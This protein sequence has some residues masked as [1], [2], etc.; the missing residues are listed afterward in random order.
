MT[1]RLL[2]CATAFA[3][4]VISGCAFIR[5]AARPIDV[6]LIIG[7][8]DSIHHFAKPSHAL[9]SMQFCVDSLG[10]PIEDQFAQTC[11]PCVSFEAQRIA[12]EGL[13]HAER[14]WGLMSNAPWNEFDAHSNCIRLSY[15]YSR[16]NE[17]SNS[18]TILSQ[19]QF[20]LS[21]GAATT[22]A[23]ALKTLDSL[24]GGALADHDTARV[25]HIYRS[26]A[27]QMMT[28]A[29]VMSMRGTTPSL[30]VAEKGAH[31]II[32]GAPTLSFLPVIPPTSEMLGES[33]AE[34]AALL[35]EKGIS[36]TAPVNE[37]ARL[38]RLSLA[39]FA[40]AGL[41]DKLDSASNAV[42]GHSPRDSVAVVA[43]ALASYH[44]NRGD[45]RKYVE[46][47]NRFTEALN[48]MPRADSAEY[49][50]F[51]DV[52]TPQDDEWRFGFLPTVRRELDRRA[53]AVVDPLWMT[54]VNEV[55]LARLA[56]KAEGDFIYAS[57]M[58]PGES[59]SASDPGILL[60]KRGSP[61]RMWRSSFH[62]TLHSLSYRWGSQYVRIGIWKDN[63]SW[64]TLYH[65]FFAADRIVK[66]RTPCP[67]TRVVLINCIR[68][69]PALWDD[70]LFY[71]RLDTIDVSLTRFRG[72]RDS[73]D[74]HV[75]ARIP[76]RS[77]RARGSS[78]A[79]AVDSVTYGLIIANSFGGRI[80]ES[81]KSRPLPS[82]SDVA[83][84]DQWTTR[85]SDGNMMHRVEAL[86]FGNARG[87]RGAAMFTSA[88]AA[89]F[90]LNGFGLSEILPASRVTQKVNVVRSWKDL[91]IV[92]NGG[93]VSPRVP[94]HL[95]WEVYGLEAGSDGQS[96]WRVSLRREEGKLQTQ[97]D[98]KSMIIGAPDQSR[99]VIASEP[100]ASGLTYQRI[101]PTSPRVVEQL[102]FNL[103]DITQGR[104][105]FI[106]TV[107]D[108]IAKKTVRREVGFSILPQS[109]QDR[110]NSRHVRST[111]TG[112][113][114]TDADYWREL[115]MRRRMRNSP[116]FP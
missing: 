113:Q 76:T 110:S 88:D 102:Q 101:A 55:R 51:T 19:A 115:L 61:S 21:S 37:K 104:H 107:E 49:D 111:V 66:E 29:R 56:R 25:A 4:S 31:D 59:G 97:F 112:Y 105:V 93:V 89:V 39:S 80:F 68:N 32:L 43:R 35:F 33:E 60:M 65:P 69:R 23:I 106:L 90:H 81:L 75:G 18:A 96:R 26:L 47:E 3:V 24:I 62:R 86:D 38:R 46:I 72:N 14:L 100:D 6:A 41:W 48:A 27:D 64:R 7:P 16:M 70:V 1:T 82:A 42:L 74:I 5:S 79:L 57:L 77:F 54:S 116:I 40:V 45:M 28:R 11:V 73:V 63:D 83:W 2:L 36:F 34:W 20:Q 91:D 87:A 67:Q 10:R 103:S 78:G 8:R 84:F 50:D 12:R 52:Y 9:A 95:V 85:V 15:D 13:R 17:D 114:M 92:P 53:W 30:N 94:V 71:S 109:A 108:M 98:V 44:L 99:Q 22:R 58:K